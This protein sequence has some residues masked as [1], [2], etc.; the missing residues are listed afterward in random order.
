MT[1]TSHRTYAVA[2]ALVVFFLSWATISARPW[3]VAKSDPRLVALQAREQQ[4][5]IDGKLVAQVVDR[6][7]ATYRVALR[8]RNLQIA[9]ARSQA[10]QAAQAPAVRLVT[11]PPLTVTRSS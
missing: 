7:W 8:G 2:I 6:R 1:D 10:L 11:L 9:H 3:T 4:L 5:R